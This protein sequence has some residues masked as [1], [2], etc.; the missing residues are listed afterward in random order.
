MYF[1]VRFPVNIVNNLQ[2]ILKKKETGI[3]RN[4]TIG[5]TTGCFRVYQKKFTVVKSPLN[6]NF[7]N[8][9]KNF[10]GVSIIV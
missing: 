2:A 7:R 8:V 5:I 3:K 6:S 1:F 4:Q 9:C 10:M